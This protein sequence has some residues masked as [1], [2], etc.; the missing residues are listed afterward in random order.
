MD[1]L[2]RGPELVELL[3][4]HGVDVDDASLVAVE[5]AGG[6]SNV[7]LKATWNGGCVVLKQSLPRLRVAADWEF[8][9]ARIFVEADCMSL[10]GS[11]MRGSCPEVVFVDRAAYAMGMTCAPEGGTVWKDAHMAGE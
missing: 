3:A 2:A 8:D 1:E 6:I 9:R 11:L 4:G 7:V 5:L 10:I